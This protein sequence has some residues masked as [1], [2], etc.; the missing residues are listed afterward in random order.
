MASVSSQPRFLTRLIQ[1]ERAAVRS[2]PND[3]EGDRQIMEI[4]VTNTGKLRIK[5]EDGAEG[6]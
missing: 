2:N 1:L 5:Y 3:G 6:G 4:E